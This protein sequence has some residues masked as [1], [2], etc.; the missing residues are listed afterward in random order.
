MDSI[1]WLDT[2]G[3]AEAHAA[4]DELSSLRAFNQACK[5]QEATWYSY[6]IND[7]WDGFSGEAP[8]ED[9][10]DEGTLIALYLHPDPEA[11]QLRMEIETLRFACEKVS[12]QLSG[13]RKELVELQL[14]PPERVELIN[15][16][17]LTL[18]GEIILVAAEKL[19]TR[20]QQVAEACAKAAEAETKV[21]REC[22]AAFGDNAAAHCQVAFVIRSGEWKKH[23]KGVE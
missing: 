10:Y 1:D 18:E 2:Q 11:A 3:T 14:L 20:D 15:E 8:P 13:V 7:H 6:R 19:A 21:A 9:S 4:R 16:G 12:K 23:R 22:L 17:P 5:E